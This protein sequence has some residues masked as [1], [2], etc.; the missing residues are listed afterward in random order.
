MF[1]L[2][3]PS[4]ATVKQ[5][6]K[7]WARHRLTPYLRRWQH[8][9]IPTIPAAYWSFAWRGCDLGCGFGKYLL[10]VSAQHAE[11]GYLGIDKGG[12]RGGRMCDRFA[13]ADQRNLFGIHTNAI[14]VL[15]AMPDRSLDEITIF[16][17][18]P[19]WPAKHRKK[20]W[21]YHPLLPKLT[22]LLKPGGRLVLTSNEAFYLSEWRF[23]VANHPEAAPMTLSYC[24]PIQQTEGRTHFETKFLA[25]GTPCGEVCFT[26][27][28]LDKAK[29]RSG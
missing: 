12:L 24:G 8:S 4:D 13:A 10:Q 11:R 7:V 9:D 22:H 21:S 23:A 17:P 26:R 6:H 29:N 5:L 27:G 2:P 28:Q 20:R 16:Y 14:P 1:P 19:W 15:A 3:I 18:N 25:E